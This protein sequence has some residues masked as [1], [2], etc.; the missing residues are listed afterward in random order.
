MSDDECEELM[1]LFR[2]E[3]N[4]GA[5]PKEQ[6][7]LRELLR[8]HYAEKEAKRPAAPTKPKGGARHE[9]S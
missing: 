8:M 3:R 4:G 5:T 6:E 9:S 1:F 7:R 2:V